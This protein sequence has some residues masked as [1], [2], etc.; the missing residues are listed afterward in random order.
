MSEAD[1]TFKRERRGKSKIERA[2]PGLTALV[3]ALGSGAGIYYRAGDWWLE[4]WDLQITFRYEHGRET[5]LAGKANQAERRI[6][7]ILAAR[8]QPGWGTVADRALRTWKG[9]NE[10]EYRPRF[11]CYFRHESMDTGCKMHGFSRWQTSMDLVGEEGLTVEAESY[12]AAMMA[13]AEAATAKFG[14]PRIQ[15][16]A[17]KNAGV[18]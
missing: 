5:D 10:A 9:L 4:P 7:E 2:H 13:L 3:D 1:K 16:E 15:V 18:C 14:M 11:F 17:P 6:H 8:E 12:E